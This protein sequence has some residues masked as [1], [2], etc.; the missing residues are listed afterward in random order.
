MPAQTPADKTLSKIYGKKRRWV[1]T[2]VSFR[3]LGNDPMEPMFFGQPP[4]LQEILHR[5]V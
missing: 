1:F 2:Q 4:P 3:D 5:V